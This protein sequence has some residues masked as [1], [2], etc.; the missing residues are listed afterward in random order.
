MV[1]KAI[2]FMNKDKKGTT[3][4]RAPKFL[5]IYN[6]LNYEET[7][8]FINSLEIIKRNS[9]KKVQISFVN[10]KDVKAAAM[11]ILYSRLEEILNSCDVQISINTGFNTHIKKRLEQT[12]FFHLCQYRSSSNN[13]SQKNYLSLVVQMETSEIR[14][15][16]T[17]KSKFIK[18]TLKLILNMFMAMLF[19]K[20]SIM[21]VCTLIIMVI[22]NGG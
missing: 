1:S 10:T 19:T 21:S 14:S 20:Q 15:L 4:F 5:D 6:S 12:G 2:Q 16:N 9:L 17:L 3:I 13:F 8:R 18:I 22:R 11:V 7:I